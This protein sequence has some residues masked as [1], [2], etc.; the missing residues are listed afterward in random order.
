MDANTLE[1]LQECQHQ[2]ITL[3]GSTYPTLTAHFRRTRC[4]WVLYNI[5]ATMAAYDAPLYQD[6]AGNAWYAIPINYLVSTHGGSKS[7]WQSSIT[8]LVYCG[9]LNRIKPDQHT[10]NPLFRRLYIDAIAAHK[11]P[12]SVYSVPAY[13][14]EILHQAEERLTEWILTGTSTSHA[15]KNT[16]ICAVGHAAANEIFH[17]N[18]GSSMDQEAQTIIKRIRQAIQ[19]NGYT[20]KDAIITKSKQIREAWRIM[21]THI[22]RYA[23]AVYRRPTKQEKQRFNLNTDEWI[24]TEANTD[25]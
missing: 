23:G 8:T 9:L 19:G 18:R 1:R 20:T 5:L 14:P 17:D 3:D 15:T 13:T 11:E 24:I 4:R 10:L 21:H 6:H 7:T 12:K 2:L 16:L 25:D 22:L